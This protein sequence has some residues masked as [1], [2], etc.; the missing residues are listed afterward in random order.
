MIVDVEFND[1]RVH[2]VEEGFDLVIRIGA[3]ED[4][5]HSKAVV[6]LSRRNLCQS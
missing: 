5:S 4:Q 1:K 2:L 3:L 6:W